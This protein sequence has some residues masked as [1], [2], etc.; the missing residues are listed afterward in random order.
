MPLTTFMLKLSMW[1]LIVAIVVIACMPITWWQV[2]G[3]MRGEPFDR[4]YPAGYWQDRLEYGDGRIAVRQE[5]ATGKERVVPVLIWMVRR[6]D[7]PCGREVVEILFEA[8][9]GEMMKPE[10]LAVLRDKS[11][12]LE[13]RHG[14]FLGLKKFKVFLTCCSGF[15]FVEDAGLA[16]FVGLCVR[17]ARL[18]GRAVRIAGVGN[19]KRR[20][21]SRGRGHASAAMREA[22]AFFAGRAS[23]SPCWCASQGWRRSAPGWAGSRSTAG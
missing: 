16:C 19:V 7:W 4:G 1:L 20:P 3:R 6:R 21:D 22:Q 14:I 15:N 23:P 17:E 5:L 2:A 9:G 10:L 11:R 8:G 13:S 18:D 12:P